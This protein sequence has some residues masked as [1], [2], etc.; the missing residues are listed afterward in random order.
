MG[1]TL[2]LGHAF[3]LG[4][5]TLAAP[6][7]SVNEPFGSR[8]GAAWPAPSVKRRGCDGHVNREGASLDD[9]S[10]RG[11]WALGVMQAKETH[12]GGAP[13]QRLEQGLSVGGG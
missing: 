11:L 1:R 3:L 2:G 6:I 13:A 5:D 7:R 12:V 9:V 10:R 8:A 4:G